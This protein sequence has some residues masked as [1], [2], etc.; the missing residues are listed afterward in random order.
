MAPTAR[1]VAGDRGQDLSLALAGLGLDGPAASLVG[2]ALVQGHCFVAGLAPEA[3]VAMREAIAKNPPHFPRLNDG[4]RE[5]AVLLSG[6][7]EQIKRLGGA[8]QKRLD[9]KPALEAGNKILKA[10]FQLGGDRTVRIGRL[11]AGGART[12][13]M[14]VLNVTPDSFSD[15]GRFL[16]P[17]AA[18]EQARRLFDAGASLVDV[19]GESTRPR[20]ALYGAGAAP[21]D[22]AEELRRVV[23]AIEAIA[24]ACPGAP[25]SVDTSRAEVARRAL[26]AGAVMV[27]D[28]RALADEALAGV[29]AANDAAVCLMHLPND[30]AALDRPVP[31]GDLIAEIADGLH[32]AGQRAEQHGVASHRVIVDPG[33]GFGKTAEEN[34]L[35]LGRLSWLRAAVGRPVLVGTSRKGFLGHATGRPLADRDRATAASVALA[36]AGGASIVRVH[37]VAA[38]LDAVKLADAAVRSRAAGAL[39]AADPDAG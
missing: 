29:V 37:D 8:L 10:C 6:R 12:L 32:A 35:L 30:P 17:A 23:P 26:L 3:I 21:I 38:C 4:T 24:R 39:F 27:N 36:I 9:V 11:E 14:G 5:G 25:I 15:G 20:G 31:Y 2:D 18:V 19:G 34:L 33:F 1:F 22:E 28:V 16:D 7:V 13:L